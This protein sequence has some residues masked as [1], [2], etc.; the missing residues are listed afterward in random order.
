[1]KFN[2]KRLLKEFDK[3]T[4]KKVLKLSDLSESEYWVL[5]YSLIEN[6]MVQNTCAKLSIS[7]AQ[8]F[9]IQKLALLKVEFTLKKLIKI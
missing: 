7:Q 1:M 8:Y 2:T 9:I 4:I 5:Y 6:R 3:D